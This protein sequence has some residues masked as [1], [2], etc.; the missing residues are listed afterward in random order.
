MCMLFKLV[1][2]AAVLQE[3]SFNACDLLACDVLLSAL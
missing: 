3:L 2:D 1:V